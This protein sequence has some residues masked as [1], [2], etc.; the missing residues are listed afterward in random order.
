MIE[1]D[2]QLEQHSLASD[3]MKVSCS[4]SLLSSS[5][6]MAKVEVKNTAY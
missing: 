2:F 3:E 5:L 4:C 6:A 1:V